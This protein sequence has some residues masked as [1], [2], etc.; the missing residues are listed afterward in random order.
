MQNLLISVKL[1]FNLGP[2]EECACWNGRR[3]GRD[4][5]LSYLPSMESGEISAFFYMPSYKSELVVH[6]QL[7]PGCQSY[8]IP[9]DK[10][11]RMNQCR[12]D[13]ET[14]LR[15]AGVKVRANLVLHYTSGK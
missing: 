13:L 14:V 8:G 4:A 15:L 10:Q 2:N 11:L 9:A 1:F 7:A 6:W 3:A 12:T 5:F